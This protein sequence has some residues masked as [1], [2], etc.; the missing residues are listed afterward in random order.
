MISC[1]NLPFGQRYHYGALI[2]EFA[3]GMAYANTGK[4]EGKIFTG[5]HGISFT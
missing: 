2:Q 3:K 1:L 5:H 4:L